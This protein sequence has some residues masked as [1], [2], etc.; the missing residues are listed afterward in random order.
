MLGFRRN[1]TQNQ[2]YDSPQDWRKMLKVEPVK[3]LMASVQWRVRGRGRR[4]GCGCG[5]LGRKA[6]CGQFL[7]PSPLEWGVPRPFINQRC[8]L[9]NQ[10]P[11]NWELFFFFRGCFSKDHRRKAEAD[12]VGAPSRPPHVSFGGHRHACPIPG[13][14]VGGK[15]RFGGLAWSALPGLVTWPSSWAL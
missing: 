4:F 1:K 12:F 7:L 13:C 6:I 3:D 15:C 9:C 14:R 5:F 8:L 10:V 11:C 2:T